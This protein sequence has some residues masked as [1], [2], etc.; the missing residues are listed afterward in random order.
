MQPLGRI[1]SSLHRSLA[2]FGLLRN[3]PLELDLPFRQI[4]FVSLVYDVIRYFSSKDYIL[5]VH[6]HRY[7][8]NYSALRAS[9][10]FWFCM[11]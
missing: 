6:G 7:Q 9:V 3:P 1:S 5:F 4:S 11:S 8:L 2:T 10:L